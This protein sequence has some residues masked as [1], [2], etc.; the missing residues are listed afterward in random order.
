MLFFPAV[1]GWFDPGVLRI[2]V[3]LPSGF[4]VTTSQH[5]KNP[6][7]VSFDAYYYLCVGR[8]LD[9]NTIKIKVLWGYFGLGGTTA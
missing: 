6:D 3:I 8:V 2:N 9:G 1:F 7:W 4:L 5:L